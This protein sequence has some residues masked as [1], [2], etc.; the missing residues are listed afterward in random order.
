[1]FSS[2]FLNWLQENVAK[3]KSELLFSNGPS[4]IRPGILVLVNDTDW[5]LL[6]TTEYQV[7]EFLF[8]FLHHHQSL[9]PK[10]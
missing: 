7:D 3:E 4:N 8:C 1:M 9:D 2:D 6:D 5:E 10:W